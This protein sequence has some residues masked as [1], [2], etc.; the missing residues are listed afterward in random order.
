MD[1]SV[2]EKHIPT[3]P[4]GMLSDPATGVVDTR[5]PWFVVLRVHTTGKPGDG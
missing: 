1:D 3:T 2:T 4:T 5:Y